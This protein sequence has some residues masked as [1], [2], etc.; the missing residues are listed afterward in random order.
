VTERTQNRTTKDHF[1]L[2]LPTSMCG[3]R[4]AGRFSDMGL[5]PLSRLVGGD[6]HGAGMEIVFHRSD[7]IVCGIIQY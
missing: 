6:V 1:H 4:C 2:M 7:P 3:A 5:L